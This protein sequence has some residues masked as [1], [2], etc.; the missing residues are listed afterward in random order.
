MGLSIEENPSLGSEPGV[1]PHIFESKNDG[2]DALSKNRSFLAD[3]RGFRNFFGDLSGTQRDSKMWGVVSKS[4]AL[5][6]TLLSGFP[7]NFRIGGNRGKK[8]RFSAFA[9]RFLGQ[10]MIKIDQIDFCRLN[11]DRKLV[12]S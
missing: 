9:T 6:R 2:P 3:F 7:G 12:L 1:M 5:P 11:F 4:E 10:K 8:D